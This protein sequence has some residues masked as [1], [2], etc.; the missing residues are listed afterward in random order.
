V[1]VFITRLSTQQKLHYAHT[2]YLYV[3]A[4]VLQYR[5]IISPDHH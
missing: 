3:S 4:R 1:T 5:A 2:V